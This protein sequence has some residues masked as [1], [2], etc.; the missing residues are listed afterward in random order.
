M[1]ADQS[2]AAGPEE[3]NLATRAL[4]GLFL[5][6]GGLALL[7]LVL[8][9]PAALDQGA[10]AGLATAALAVGGLMFLVESLGR[11]ARQL[12][13]L[14]GTALI[15]AGLYFGGPSPGAF[16]FLYLWVVLYS[17]Y[18]L[19]RGEGAA[20]L[21]AVG[22]A[23]AG[24]LAV[25]V[26]NDSSEFTTWVLTVGSLAVAWILV[27]KLKERV[28]VLV[29]RLSEAARTDFVTG[30][31]NR[32]G[33][34]ERLGS[35]LSRA[36]R[37]GQPIGLLIGDLDHFKATNDRLGHHAG[38]LA[39]QR[40][41]SLLSEGKRS[42]DTVARIGGEEFAVILPDSDSAGT[43]AS[44]ERLR[45]RIQLA[46]SEQEV[47]LTISLGTATFPVDGSDTESLTRAADAALYAAKEL[48][49]DRVLASE[50]GRA[51][52]FPPPAPAVTSGQPHAAPMAPEL[53]AFPKSPSQ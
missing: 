21:V 11:A 18:F 44:G 42:G 12:V 29:G 7:I 5:A 2:S 24:V 51:E 20:Q 40:V 17:A 49:R 13:P 6:G 19:S 36:H 9:H 1:R 34:T 31:L 22:L 26:Q 41:A 14:L 52:L 8:P 48:G 33:F 10:I 39:L 46:F 25:A 45:R 38:D 37:S 43:H 47:P 30:L 53:P 35:E 50:P 23:Y 15:T 16:A 3:P 28:D 4:A 32:R 27:R